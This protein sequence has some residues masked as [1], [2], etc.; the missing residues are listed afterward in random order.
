MW[1]LRK[2]SLTHF[3]QNFRET[4]TVLLNTV[5]SSLEAA[6]SITFGA[7]FDAASIQGRPLID[8][9]K[10]AKKAQICTIFNYFAIKCGLY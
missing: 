7:N 9:I 6:A 5:K 4:I 2:F 3:W 10:V 8:C 1:K